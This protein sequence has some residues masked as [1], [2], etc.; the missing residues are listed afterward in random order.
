MKVTL[1]QRD[2]NG[3]ISLYLDYYHKSKRKLEYLRLYLIDKPRTSEE[4][5]FNK[6]TLQLAESIRAKRQLELQSGI[7]GFEDSEKVNSLFLTYFELLAEKRRDSDG[8][9]GNWLSTLKHL[10]K[11]KKSN[12]RFADIDRQW[13]EDLKL[14]FVN[15]AKTKQGKSL[16]KNSC[17][18]YFN[19]VRAALKEAVK[20]GIIMRNPAEGVDGIKEAETKREFLTLEE[21]KRAVKAHCEIEV[22]KNAFIFSALTGLRFSDIEK[23]TWSEIHH[24]DE[25][26]YYIRFKQKKTKGQET[27]PIAHDALKFMGERKDGSEKVFED[28]TYSDYNNAK[29]REWMIRAGIE[30]HITFH[31]ARHTYATLQLSLGTDIYTVSKLLGHKSLKTTEVYAKII[32]QKKVE[33]ANR[34]KL[35]L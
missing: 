13:L 31:C 16:S 14:Y 10:R 12:V 23:L 4:R 28:L 25:N 6:K 7:Y 24:S 30:K 21:L 15:E 8:N 9:Y 32:D 5:S 2:K 11:W 35:D 27:L 1:R 34:I 19:K 17:V 26:G 29:I 3:K 22:V 20:D 18:S 33:A